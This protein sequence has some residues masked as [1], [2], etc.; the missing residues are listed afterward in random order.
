MREIPAPSAQA[1]ASPR[2]VVDAC[3]EGNARKAAQYLAASASASEAF[4]QPVSR[5]RVNEGDQVENWVNVAGI[6]VGTIALGPGWR[7]VLWVQGCPFCCDDCIAPEW[8]TRRPASIVK[9][10]T[11]AARLLADPRIDGLTFS[12]GEPM[13]QAASLADVV[14]H[15]R[16]IRDISLVCYTGYRFEQLMDQPP[17]PGVQE[18]LSVTDVLIDGPYKAELNDGRGLRGS[19]NQKVHFLTDRLR[20]SESEFVGPSRTVEIRVSGTEAL[21]VGIPPRNLMDALDVRYPGS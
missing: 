6:C 14:M 10:R 12:G 11:L 19:A 9:S 3:D 20:E 4:T 7:S 8:I 21:L 2:E 16:A 1:V 17:N 15:A 13:L 18:L 5:S